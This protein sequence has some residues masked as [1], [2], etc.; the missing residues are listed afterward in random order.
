MHMLKFCVLLC[1]LFLILIFRYYFKKNLAFIPDKV[2]SLWMWE[3]PVLLCVKQYVSSAIYDKENSLN[4][5]YWV[6]L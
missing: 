4:S 2:K 6:L 3:I 1:S 5:A